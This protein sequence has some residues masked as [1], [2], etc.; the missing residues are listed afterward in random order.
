MVELI[1]LVKTFL[2]SLLNL[3]DVFGFLEDTNFGCRKLTMTTNPLKMNGAVRRIESMG[4]MKLWRQERGC[5]RV[6]TN[7]D[8]PKKYRRAVQ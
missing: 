5:C 1:A 3:G 7:N 6:R 8:N 2:F 4:L